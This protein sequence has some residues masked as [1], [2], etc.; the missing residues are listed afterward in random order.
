MKKYFILFMFLGVTGLLFSGLVAQ[1]ENN[2]ASK[3]VRPLLGQTVK[4]DRE[5]FREKMRSDREAFMQKLQADRDAFKVEIEKRKEEFKSATAA[6]KSEWRGRA[7]EMIGQRFEVA[8]RN[9]ERMQ[10]RVADV[11]EKL[12]AD[13]KDTTDAENALDLSKQKLDDAKDK[14]EQIKDLLPDTGDKITT[15]IFAQIK[16]LA[17]E[18]KDLLKESR[19]N[20]VQAIKEIGSLR[21]EN[22][23]E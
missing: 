15:E 21:G 9:L 14:I 4:N 18:A 22:E 19:N 12:D 23:S 2:G 1:A 13:G 16:L 7:Q 11:L 17:R 8:V 6:Q 5:V 3:L 20:L 10:G